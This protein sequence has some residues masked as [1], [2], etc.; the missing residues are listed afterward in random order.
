MKQPAGGPP[1]DL[2]RLRREFPALGDDDIRAYEEVTRRILGAAPEALASIVVER[3]RPKALADP[4]AMGLVVQI[5]L[6]APF[7][8]L[9]G[10]R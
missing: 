6:D 4:E 9:H 3:V 1:V 8:L 5:D 10:T 2:D 7:V